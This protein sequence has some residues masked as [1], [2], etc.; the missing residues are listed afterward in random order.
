MLKQYQ[1]KQDEKYKRE[2]KD[3]FRLRK[4]FQFSF[5]ISTFSYENTTLFVLCLLHLN[6]CT[7]NSENNILLCFYV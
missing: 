4:P 5:P 3:L 7:W 6:I 2:T 1:K